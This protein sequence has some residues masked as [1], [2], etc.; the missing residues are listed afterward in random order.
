[1][2]APKSSASGPP[3]AKRGGGSPLATGVS[4]AVVA[5]DAQPT[6]HTRSVSAHTPGRA[7]GVIAVR[8]TTGSLKT[9]ETS[10]WYTLDTMTSLT[11]DARSLRRLLSRMPN[12]AVHL[13]R[14]ER[15]QGARPGVK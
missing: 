8:L 14:T 13:R 15:P 4:R 1:M 2:L 7:R 3:G 6:A 10:G 5:G 9:R 11:F 12:A